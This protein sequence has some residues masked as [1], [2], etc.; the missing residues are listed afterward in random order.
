MAELGERRPLGPTPSLTGQLVVPV[1]ELA[2]VL[3]D[4]VIGFLSW[5]GELD[6]ALD[7]QLAAYVGDRAGF[8]YALTTLSTFPDGTEYVPPAPGAGFRR[9]GHHL[10]KQFR[11]QTPLGD[12]G[13]ALVPHLAVPTA[14]GPRQGLLERL[15]V[16]CHAAEVWLRAADG[17]VLARY[18][19]GTS[20]A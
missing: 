2:A 1:P 7:R 6:A 10:H 13:H 4:A 8:D 5:A 9:L 3:S 16:H 14:P 11:E 18:A 19:F 20:A 15:P 12:F 17:E